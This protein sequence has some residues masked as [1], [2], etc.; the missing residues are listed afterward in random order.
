[1]KFLI[2]LLF[3]LITVPVF[4]EP[5][6]ERTGM[7]ASFDV[8]VDD[9]IFV[10]KS[11]A[12]FDIRSV[13]FDNNTIVLEIKSSLENNLAELQIPQNITRGQIKF[14]LDGNEIPAKILQNDK[15]SFATLEFKGN[16]THTLE[17]TSDYS[18]EEITEQPEVESLDN[19]PD[20]DIMTIAAVLGIVIATGAASTLA[21]YFKRRTKTL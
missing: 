2:A 19:E 12:N 16:G 15:I 8:R 4:A 17:I 21:V 7:S 1:M 13:R 3:S 9:E 11:T 20:N 14:Y 5:L 18:K 10:V 6:S